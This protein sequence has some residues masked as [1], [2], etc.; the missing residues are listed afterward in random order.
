MM[1]GDPQV[2]KTSLLLRYTERTYTAK[3]ISTLG[4]DFKQRPLK[5]EGK[6]FQVQV[7]DTA[8]QE[9]LVLVL[10]LVFGFFCC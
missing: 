9:R 7:W 1:L 2:G 3:Y 10:V 4:V 5:V 8:G 6:E